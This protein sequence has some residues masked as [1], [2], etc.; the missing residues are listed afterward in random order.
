MTTNLKRRGFS[1][2]EI[3]EVLGV[4]KVQIYKEIESGT[5]KSIHIGQKHVI[6]D[7]DI[8][9]RFGEEYANSIMVGVGCIPTPE[10]TVFLDICGDFNVLL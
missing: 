4:S 2:K 7:I 1:V 6:R 9:E 8:K 3:A 5:L 10:N